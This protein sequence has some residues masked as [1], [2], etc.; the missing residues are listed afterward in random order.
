MS[1]TATVNDG[2][3]ATYQWYYQ[4]SLTGGPLPITQSV[5]NVLSLSS[6]SQT[7]VGYYYVAV[8]NTVGTTNSNVVYLGDETAPTITPIVSTP[9]ILG[10]ICVNSTIQLSST[11]DSKRKTTPN[12]TWSHNSQVL[13][14]QNSL[15]LKCFRFRPLSFTS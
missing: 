13:N 7:N 9:S 8:T 10:S 15:Q 4:Q 1:V 2:S 5:T 14:N 11:F 3:I 12:I 6:F